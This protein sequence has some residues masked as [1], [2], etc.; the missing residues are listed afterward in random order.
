MAKKSK[1]EKWTLAVVFHGL[2]LIVPR[3]PLTVLLPKSGG[4]QGPKH[5]A[6]LEYDEAY[7]H[8]DG[9]A[10]TVGTATEQIF[11]ENRTLSIKPDA[12]GFDPQPPESVFDFFRHPGSDSKRRVAKTGTL[13]KSPGSLL[14]A[15]VKLSRGRFEAAAK[16]TCW[17]V[18]GGPSQEL[19]HAVLWVAENVEGTTLEA[20]LAP[21]GDGAP[22]DLPELYP[23]NGLLVLNVCHAPEHDFKH[24][25]QAGTQTGPQ[26]G[27]VGRPPLHM[28]MYYNLL[29]PGSDTE[30]IL[31][32]ETPPCSGLR[33]AVWWE[34]YSASITGVIRTTTTYSCM[35]ATAPPA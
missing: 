22:V 20:S 26:A 12:K 13:G 27:D 17:S 23:R 14:D 32:K 10:S 7:R 28:H 35:I 4:A 3:T 19:T 24:P 5:V 16:G 33:Q 21:F 6:W 30:P 9:H 18:D 8:P 11:L 25:I 1:P 2:C 31:L 15:R 34:E 29:R